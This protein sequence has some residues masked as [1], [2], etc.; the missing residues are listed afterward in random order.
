M[1]SVDL[2]HFDTLKTP[3]FQLRRPN[4]KDI[5]AYQ[6]IQHSDFVL[7][8]NPM[9]KMSEQEIKKQF[10]EDSNILIM[11]DVN[12]QLI[13]AIFV[14]HGTIRYWNQAVELSYFLKQECASQGFM[15]EALAYLMQELF[16]KEDIKVITVRVF[17]ENIHSINLAKKLGFKQEGYIHDCVLHQGKLFDDIIFSLTKDDFMKGPFFI[18]NF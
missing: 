7:Q 17:A 14:H 11:E 3:R 4:E 9:P 1:S 18:G 8:H 5:S 15:S 6:I 2:F 10:D 12:Q 16:L 13:G